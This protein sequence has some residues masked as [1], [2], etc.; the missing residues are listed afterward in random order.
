MR[1]FKQKQRLEKSILTDGKV[2][3]IEYVLEFF[4]LYVKNVFVVV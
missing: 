2:W 1:R 3:L 4:D